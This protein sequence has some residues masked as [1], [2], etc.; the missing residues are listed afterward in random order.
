[1]LTSDN[2]FFFSCCFI[3]FL[4]NIIPLSYLKPFLKGAC[5][6]QLRCG[7]LIE[8]YFLCS[9]ACVSSGGHR[10]QHVVVNVVMKLD[11]CCQH[12]SYGC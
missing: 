10:T 3:R 6:F 2:I 7:I 9:G 12:N 4:G 11:E 8:E 1:M 5:N